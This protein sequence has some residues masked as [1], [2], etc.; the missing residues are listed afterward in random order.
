MSPCCHAGF[1]SIYRKT[2][3]K[4]HN[5]ITSPLHKSARHQKKAI[6]LNKR[7]HR[8]NIIK[9]EKTVCRDVLLTS[10]DTVTVKTFD[11]PQGSL[12]MH[13]RGRLV[14]LG[15]FTNTARK[16]SKSKISNHHTYPQP[17]HLNKSCMTGGEYKTWNRESGLPFHSTVR[18]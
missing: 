9:T 12:T 11:H 8:Q 5:P 18:L 4:Q 16:V 15:D 1:P 2:K 13:R 17:A 6:S 3:T 10:V 7:P 14:S